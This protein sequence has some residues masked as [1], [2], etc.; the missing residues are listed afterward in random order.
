MENAYLIM[1]NG[2]NNNN[3]FYNL[4]DNND[5]T[6]TAEYGRVGK[7]TQRKTYSIYEWDKK[8]WEKVGKGYRDVTRL[9]SEQKATINN[10][11]ENDEVR[12]LINKLTGYS[13]DFIKK[14]YTVGAG[15]VTSAM[16]EDVQNTIAEMRRIAESNGSVRQFNW[17]IQDILSAIPRQVVKVSDLLAETSDDFNDILERE[18]SILNVMQSEVRSREVMVGGKDMLKAHGLTIKPVTK[19]QEKE[20]LSHLDDNT[21]RHFKRAFKVVNKGTSDRF[22]K[23]CTDNDYKDGD[24]KFLYHGSRNQNWLGIIQQGL[25]LNNKAP[26]TGAMFSKGLYFA[27]SSNKS[28]GYV[29]L[30][31]TRWNPECSDKG[32]MAVYKV[33]VRKPHDVY[34]HTAECRNFSQADMDRRGCDAVWAHAGQSLRA[35]EVIVY[36]ENRC[37][38]EY[39][40]EVGI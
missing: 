21:R 37:T 29:S 35:D 6:F 13:Q 10:D 19:K 2:E 12:D 1:V 3:K 14:N 40:I 11:I 7:S 28:Y 5:G 23:F 33:A 36:S 22:N 27:P 9:K 24:I 8:Y 4:I 39:L 20:I 32:Y 34:R 25:T 16:T 38:I 30:P 17:C 15:G 26:K 18:Q 31:G